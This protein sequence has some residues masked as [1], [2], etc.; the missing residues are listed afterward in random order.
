MWREKFSSRNEPRQAKPAK[1][2]EAF[3]PP[4]WF[5]FRDL[6]DRSYR[7]RSGYVE[8]FMETGYFEQPF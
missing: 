4:H 3:A 5:P 2:R 6:S 8:Q 1:R 7:T